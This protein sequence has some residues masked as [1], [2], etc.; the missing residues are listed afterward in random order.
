[1]LFLSSNFSSN[2]DWSNT[3]H[4]TVVLIVFIVKT[5]GLDVKRLLNPCGSLIILYYCNLIYFYFVP[6]LTT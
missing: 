4:V 3:D 6:E 5:Q 1:M 2:N